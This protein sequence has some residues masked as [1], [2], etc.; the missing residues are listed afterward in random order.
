MFRLEI[1]KE[2][3]DQSET[4]HE[5]E[6]VVEAAIE[7]SATYRVYLL[8]YQEAEDMLFEG[9]FNGPKEEDM[10]LEAIGDVLLP[11][12]ISYSADEWFPIPTWKQEISNMKSSTRRMMKAIRKI[13][14]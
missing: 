13:N 1:T 11:P 12:A 8:A 10:L 4:S 7:V 14:A 2:L 9:R 6:D 3:Y 5:F